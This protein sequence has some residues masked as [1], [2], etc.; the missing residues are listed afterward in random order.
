MKHRYP[1]YFVFLCISIVFAN[2]NSRAQS[3]DTIQPKSEKKIK[4]W[5]FGAVPAIAY[6]SDIGFKYGGIVNFYDYGDG[7]IYPDYRHSIYLEWS[8][9]TKGS[10]INQIAYDS[11]SLIKGIRLTGDLSYFIE[12]ALDFYGFNGYEAAYNHT[13]EDDNPVNSLYK[14][15]M[16]YR[17]DRRML[18]FSLDFQSMNKKSKLQWLTGYSVFNNTIADVDINQLNKGRDEADKLPAVD[19]NTSLFSKY[20]AWGVIPQDQQQGGTQQFLK[21]GLVYDTRDNEPNP[22]NG[23][24]SEAILMV[25][26]GFLGNKFSYTQL[27]VTHRHYFTLKP[28]I[29]NLA[30]RVSWQG[31]ILGEMP[32]YMLP[33]LY[34]S[35]KPA[36]DGLGGAKT[37]R[38][39]LRNRVV[40][41]GM[42]YGNAELR[43]KFWRTSLFKQNFYLALCGFTDMGL[44]TH[45]FKFNT[46]NIPDNYKIVEDEERLHLSYGAGLHLVLNSNFIVSFDYG[47]SA[48]IQ[49]GESGFYINL[50]FLY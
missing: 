24:W 44:V 5:S 28:K 37:L 7:N 18:R 9:T 36:R 39:I 41:E 38:G 10:G 2:S 23:I 43:W 14:S 22:M 42:L 27:T 15:R 11:K 12:Q 46:S 8:R 50:N 40:G 25:S 47:R 32:Y 16:F 4:G 26:P 6:D 3:T 17:M 21:I 13:F 35:N 20:K 34:S 29:L 1:F 30:C 49:D 48:N 33:L 31:K 45:K 19:T